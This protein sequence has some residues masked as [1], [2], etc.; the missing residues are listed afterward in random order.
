VSR[1]R[2]AACEIWSGAGNDFALVEA[3][4]IRGIGTPR[5][6]A[7]VAGAGA[8]GR[9]VDGL[10]VVA[11][12]HAELW[13][14]DGSHPAFCGNGA[15]CV[16]ARRLAETGAEWVALRFGRV[17]LR[18]WREGRGIAIRVP[19][20][21]T[22]RRRP[23]PGPIAAALAGAGARLVDA[24]WIEAGVPHLCL[25]F[26]LA[27]GPATRLRRIGGALRRARGFGP[28]GT[29][30]TFVWPGAGGVFEVR[31]YERGVEDL[32]RA[33]GSGALAAARLLRDGGAAETVR[34]RVASGARLTVRAEASG[35]VLCGPAR[36]ITRRRWRPPAPARIK[37]SARGRRSGG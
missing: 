6:L 10:I 16:A 1:P 2:E 22:R 32:T 11:G 26:A 5:A 14:R 33:C 30:V 35:W 21:R 28:G 23:A 13:N 20:P 18:A 3:A 8:C 29:N 17:R 12:A 34:L 15:R 24:A 19:R 31:T 37:P 36:R 4:A 7:R 25:R 9:R 27:P